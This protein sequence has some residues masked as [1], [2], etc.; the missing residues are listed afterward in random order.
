M[1]Q[2]REIAEKE[3]SSDLAS[4]AIAWVLRFNYTSTGLFGVRNLEQFNKCLKALEVYKKLTPE[5][6]GRINKILDTNPPKLLD[7]RTHTNFPSLRPVA[8]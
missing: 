1:R 3:L 4:L 8:E 5:I 6:E 2:I 7:F